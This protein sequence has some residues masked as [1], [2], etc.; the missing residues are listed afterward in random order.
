MWWQTTIW[1]GAALVVTTSA[2]HL[3]I[4]QDLLSHHTST[5]SPGTQQTTRQD[6]VHVVSE[7]EQHINS[8]ETNLKASNENPSLNLPNGNKGSRSNENGGSAAIPVILN[9]SGGDGDDNTGGNSNVNDGNGSDDNASGNGNENDGNDSENQ[10]NGGNDNGGDGNESDNDNPGENDGNNN[11]NDSGNNQGA[12]DGNDNGSDDEGD[13][14]DDNPENDDTE[15]KYDVE[16]TS[17]VVRGHPW[18]ENE[19]II[20]Y[21][22]IKYGS[23]NTPL[24]APVLADSSETIHDK[25]DHN[26]RCPQLQGDQYVGDI[27]CLTLSIFKP[28]DASSASVLVHIHE[29]NFINGSGNPEIYGPEYLVSKGIILVLP[30]YRLGPLGFLC[31]QN[32]TAPGN[33]ALKDLSLALGWI[34]ENIAKF[35][36]NHENIAVSGDGTAGALAGYLA[37]SPMSKNDIS[38][39]IT[40]SGSVLSYWAIDRNPINSATNLV[41]RISGF[42]TWQNVGAEQLVRAAKDVDLR[43]CLERNIDNSSHFMEFTPSTMIRNQEIKIAFMIG[44]AQ[45]AGV[46]E[47]FSHTRESIHE[48]NLDASLMLPNDLHFKTSEERTSA[49]NRV[50]AAYF[51]DTVI[52][53]CDVADLALYFTD[54]AYLGPGIR[55]ARP[56]VDSG[57]TVYLYEFSFVGSL[58]RELVAVQRQVEGAVRGDI[59]G[60]LFTQDGNVLR[61]DS[62]ESRMIN[63][64]TELWTTFLK[65]GTPSAGNIEWK[66]LD[67]DVEPG[68]EHWLSI[69]TE[70]TLKK[71]MHVERLSVWTDIYD[72]HFIEKSRAPG[73]SASVYTLIV[74]QIVVFIGF[75]KNARHFF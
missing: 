24:Q 67:K 54:A 53:R 42:Q 14:G 9:D 61:E 34:K 11:G 68:E 16:T 1:I 31:L 32:E 63:I 4:E 64:L 57:A 45:Y 60:Y 8:G 39:V 18:R 20:S 36:G 72:A 55:T 73:T 65:T 44:S 59:I 19:K 2:L 13:V 33:A 37:L 74:L 27:D 66:K 48:F 41:R 51:G 7:N 21:I 12:S 29:G 30:N 62:K 6:G 22:D 40:E 23:I 43:P 46:H 58:N 50:R 52:C 70:P 47:L 5:S 49:G 10:G 69:E 56:L 35:G 38:K 71:G 26:K 28:S 3:T 75:F 15:N 25:K 17:G